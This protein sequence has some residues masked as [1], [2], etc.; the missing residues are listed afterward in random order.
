MRATTVC[1]LTGFVTIVSIAVA[2]PVILNGDLD[3][4][5]GIN[6]APLQWMNAQA[7]P[8]VA[9][10]SGPFNNTGV[11]WT[12]SPNGGT[13]AR[14]NGVGSEQSEG[15]SQNVT[16][17]I[18]GEIYE[19]SFFATNLGFRT[20]STGA[21]GGFDGYFEFYA[22]GELVAT[23]DALSKQSSATDPIEWVQQ[24]VQF[25]A[26][27]SEF[28]LEIR[29]ETVA[30]PFQIAYMGLDGVDVSVVPAPSALSALA[31]LGFT[32]TRRRR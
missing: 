3:G 14:M 19:L 30:D 7:T 5:V 12:V 32:S 23:S 20:N 28:L 18:A 24:S 16:G 21:W 1:T 22:D 8:D 11:P 15:I 26:S 10:A 27:S 31:M 25:E 2:E 29:A 9:N 4:N 17:F 6:T 13:F